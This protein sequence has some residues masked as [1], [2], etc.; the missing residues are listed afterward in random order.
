VRARGLGAATPRVGQISYFFGQTL[1]FFGQKPAAKS[2]KNIF[3]HLLKE[4]HGI[5]SAQRDEVP[6]I[7]DFLQRVSIA[8]YAERCLSHDRSCQ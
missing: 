2:E 3:W 4:K 5:Y 6:E 8:C 1:N 7:Q